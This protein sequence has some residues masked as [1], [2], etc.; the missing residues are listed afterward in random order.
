M[1]LNDT[2]KVIIDRF[3]R[4]ILN[5]MTKKGNKSLLEYTEE[6]LYDTIINEKFIIKSMARYT[7]KAY[8]N[9]CI[10]IRETSGLTANILRETYKPK[11]DD[12]LEIIQK[13]I[14][15]IALEHKE[16]IEEWDNLTETQQ[17]EQIEIDELI[18]L[19]EIR[20]K[21]GDFDY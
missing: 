15:T 4:G 6:E 3:M 5:L 9:L 1:I 20:I 2:E 19:N 7:K 21:K 12:T 10:L 17:Q 13:K 18:R 16:E 11:N 14:I 8:I